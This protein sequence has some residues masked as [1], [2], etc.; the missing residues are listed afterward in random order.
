MKNLV[1]VIFVLFI[2]INT[3]AGDYSVEVEKFIEGSIEGLRIETDAHDKTWR[4][5]SAKTWNVDQDKGIIFWSLEDG[6]IAVAP[7]QIIGTY[8][9][10]DR[11][12]L[13]GWDHPSVLKPLQQHSRLVK[14]YGEKHGVKLFT[15]KKVHVSEDQAWEFSAVA[16][17]LAEANGAYRADAG[18]PLVYMTFGEIELRN[19]QP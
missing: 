10:K 13:W 9:P 15:S 12:F 4:L 19:Q 11:S 16:S 2:S 6:R 8:N 1:S 18:G 17:R 3:H 14:E 7:V 5:G